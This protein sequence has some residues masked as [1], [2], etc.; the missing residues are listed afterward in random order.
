MRKENGARETEGGKNSHRWGGARVST[1]ERT[2]KGQPSLR[3]KNILRVRISEKEAGEDRGR[4]AG[5]GR[6]WPGGRKIQP[7]GRAVLSSPA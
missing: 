2:E 1:S 3:F 7:D 4:E 5:S 6:Q